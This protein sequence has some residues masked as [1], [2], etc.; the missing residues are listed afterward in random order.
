M[1]QFAERLRHALD[2]AYALG[3]R[4]HHASRFEQYLSILADAA[5]F[6][7]PRPMMWGDQPEKQ[8][9]FFEAASQSQ[10]LTD[11]AIIWPTIEP[12]T[13]KMKVRTILGGTTLPPKDPAVDDAPRNILFEFAGRWVS[14]P[15]VCMNVEA[16]VYDRI[17]RSSLDRRS[18]VKAVEE[19]SVPNLL[20]AR[21]GGLEQR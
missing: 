9:L 20:D 13:A 21:N 14:F 18:P 11:A 8:A 4:R 2:L 1:A 16:V 19:Q 6:S 3:V 10:Q 17:H 5:S 15:T 12:R 7:Y